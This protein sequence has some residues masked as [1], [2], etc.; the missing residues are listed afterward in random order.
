MPHAV[1]SGNISPSAAEGI[2]MAIEVRR[3]GVMSYS[4]TGSKIAL[5]HVFAR[6]GRAWLSFRTLRGNGDSRYSVLIHSD[7]YADVIRAMLHADP[8]EAVKAIGAALQDGIP[9]RKLEDG[10]EWSPARAA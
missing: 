2:A 1:K 3:T 6:Y 9:E 7:S 5:G 10:Q 8:Q 4:E